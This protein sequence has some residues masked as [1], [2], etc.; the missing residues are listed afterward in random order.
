[1]SDP[2]KFLD[3]PLLKPQTSMKL[4][5]KYLSHHGSQP[6]KAKWHKFIMKLLKLFKVIIMVLLMVNYPQ[7]LQEIRVFDFFL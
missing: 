7:G 6:L 2:S 4:H 1:M 5:L 3:Q